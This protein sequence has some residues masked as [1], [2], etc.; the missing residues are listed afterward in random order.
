[1]ISYIMA[2]TIAA[3]VRRPVSGLFQEIETLQGER[4]WGR[5]LDAGTGTHSIGWIGTLPTEQWTA[6]TGADAHAV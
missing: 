5:M 2:M 1:M 4:P 3:Q 6:V